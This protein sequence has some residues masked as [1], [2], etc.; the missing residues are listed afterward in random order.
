M[1]SHNVRTPWMHHVCILSTG[2]KMV[3]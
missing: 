1:G 3:Y 2:L